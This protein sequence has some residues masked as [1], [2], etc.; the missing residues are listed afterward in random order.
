[1]SEAV[2]EELIPGKFCWNELLT[3]DLEA[4]K[5]FYGELFGWTF[6][7]M[8]MPEGEYTFLKNGDQPGG[9]M[10]QIQKEWGEVPPH[11]MSYVAVDDVVASVEKAK[12][13]GG[14][15]LQDAKQVGEMG[16][17][18]IVQDPTGAVLAFWKQGSGS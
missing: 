10:M 3:P 11:W 18:A 5:K 16:T 1:M 6:D 9:G 15:I 12:S 7:S 14:T 8:P 13:L 17:F 2:K 4:A